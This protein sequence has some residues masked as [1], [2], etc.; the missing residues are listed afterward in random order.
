[1]TY[2]TGFGILIMPSLPPWCSLNFVFAG[3]ILALAC[4]CGNPRAEVRES[5]LALG[6]PIVLS[7]ELAPVIT[8][9]TREVTGRSR[10][11]II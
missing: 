7:T 11:C 6:S 5:V 3:A 9:D 8:E 2:V 10:A 1:M 4:G